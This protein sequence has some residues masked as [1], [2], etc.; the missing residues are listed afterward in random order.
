MHKKIFWLEDHPSFWTIEGIEELSEGKIKKGYLLDNTTFAYDY[1]SAEK[2]L[3]SGDTFDLYITD[4]D[5]P[6]KMRESQKERIDAFFDEL[7]V[8]EPG[9]LE[10][11]FRDSYYGAGA[12]FSFRYLLDK[13]FVV[14]SMS[15]D[16]KRLTFLLGW[17]MYEKHAWRDKLEIPFQNK[18]KFSHFDVTG[19]LAKRVFDIAYSYLKNNPEW[20]PSDRHP[21][22]L[23]TYKTPEMIE[24]WEHGGPGDLVRDRIVPLF[25]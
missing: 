11:G 7:R 8:G 9:K 19:N 18:N 10:G 2:I 21:E 23:D 4:W 13:N 16:A 20:K 1:V 17:S 25:E 14:H 3:K 24:R 22:F 15:S 6:A 5:F 12:E